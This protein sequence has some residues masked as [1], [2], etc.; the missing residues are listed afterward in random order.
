VATAIGAGGILLTRIKAG[1]LAQP[2]D[3]GL[4]LGSDFLG[5]WNNTL[6]AWKSYMDNS[7][8]FYLAGMGANGLQWD[9]AALSINGTLTVGTAARSGT[10]MTGA[11]FKA[12]GG[13][14]T[15]VWGNATTNLTFNGTTMTM[16]GSWVTS[17]NISGTIDTSKVN[18]GAFTAT[19]STSSIGSST[20]GTG[21][22]ATVTVTASGGDA[23]YTYSWA[24]SVFYEVGDSYV[25]MNSYTTNSANLEVWVGTASNTGAEGE[26]ICTV[27]D[28][29][30]RVA[31]A[32]IYLGALG[33][34]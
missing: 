31:T 3:T 11:G 34:V 27:V 5:Y 26:A 6:G 4:Y 13:D 25:R 2:T 18:F 23:P 14:G 12:D 30:G 29:N 32:T 10:T 19:P 9:G 16:N 22:S 24:M 33:T 28:K 7:G 17:A 1:Q 15:G 8:R 20:L 21:A